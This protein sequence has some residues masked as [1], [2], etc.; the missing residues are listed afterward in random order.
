MNRDDI[1]RKVRTKFETLGASISQEDRPDRRRHLKSA[2]QPLLAALRE[3][4][5]DVD[6]VYDLV[7]TTRSYHRALPVLADHLQRDYPPRILE[8]IARALAVRQAAPYWQVLL[9]AYQSGADVG[10]K[11]GAA[12]AIAAAATEDHLDA[13]LRV[14][15][16]EAHGSSRVLLMPA[17]VRLGDA[18]VVEPFLLKL[19]EHPVI[20]REAARTLRRRQKR[21]A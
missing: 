19:T 5:E 17:L 1:L 21:E 4:G 6:S 14:V 11:Q 20:G 8:G 2:E 10:A 3:V 12:C 18:A 16:D 13:L 7:N 15:G 9:S